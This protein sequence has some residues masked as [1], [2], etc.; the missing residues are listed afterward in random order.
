MELPQKTFGWNGNTQE[1]RTDRA[2]SLPPIWFKSTRLHC[3][4]G[5]GQHTSRAS[6]PLSDRSGRDW[7]W[8]LLP[9]RPDQPVASGHGKS[10]IWSKTRPL[11]LQRTWGTSTTRCLAAA[12]ARHHLPPLLL[13]LPLYNRVKP[14]NYTFTPTPSSQLLTLATCQLGLSISL[15]AR[16]IRK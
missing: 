11:V 3:I 4:P 16:P 14:C 1:R 2:V 8:A 7:Y 6:L 9:D 5:N 15:Y 13:G 10:S 12:G